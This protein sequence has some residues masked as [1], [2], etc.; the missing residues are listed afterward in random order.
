ML[1]TACTVPGNG[2]LIPLFSF[3][4]LLI[5]RGL[6]NE[7]QVKQ[8]EAEEQDDLPLWGHNPGHVMVAEVSMVHRVLYGI[9]GKLQNKSFRE[10]PLGS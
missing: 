10:D 2:A 9:S 6:E 7:R 4:K 5:S 3:R 8:A 1:E